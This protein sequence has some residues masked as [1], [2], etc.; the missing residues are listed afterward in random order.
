M[1]IAIFCRRGHN[2]HEKIEKTAP[3]APPGYPLL[4]PGYFLPE[5]PPR[6]SPRPPR[7]PLIVEIQRVI[8]QRE[9]DEP[10]PAGRAEEMVP[11]IPVP[12]LQ[13]HVP[14]SG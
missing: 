13:P 10:V 11:R 4:P 7:D 5:R 1:K 6:A 3:G 9:G 14:E 2:I 12:N 8:S